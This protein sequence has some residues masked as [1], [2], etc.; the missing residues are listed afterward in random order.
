MKEGACKVLGVALCG[1]LLAAGCL[2]VYLFRGKRLEMVESVK[3]LAIIS[4][5][6]SALMLIAQ[7][8]GNAI[9]KSI[10]QSRLIYSPS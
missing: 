8:I 2:S 7:F 5:A 6:L 9:L 3:G 1:M 4:G 10:A